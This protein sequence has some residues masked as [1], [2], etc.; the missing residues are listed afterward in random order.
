[1]PTKIDYKRE[2]KTLYAPSAKQFSLVDVP[3]LN[4][5]MVDGAG[6]PNSAP[7]YAEAVSTLYAVAYALKFAVKQQLGTDYTVMPL[8]G[9][10]WAEKMETFLKREKEAWQ[11]TMMIM[12]PEMVTADLVQASIEQTEKKKDLPALSKVRFEPYAE[13]KAA[14]ILY[15]GS[16]DDETDTIANLH[17]FIEA[18]DYQLRGKHHEI[19]LSDPRRVAPEKLKTVIRQPIQSPAPFGEP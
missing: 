15:Y 10:W 11:W 2:F 1:M 16:Y 12:Q 14:Q 5:L 3:T 7:A 8:E 4:F 17:Q 9:L 6:N 18:N 13:G 19:Y